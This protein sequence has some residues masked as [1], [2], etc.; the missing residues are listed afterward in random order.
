MKIKKEP[1]TRETEKIE[2]TIETEKIKETKEIEE[3]E[4]INETESIE[5]AESIKEAENTKASKPG[6][7]KLLG[8]GFILA[9]VVLLLMSCLPEDP[10]DHDDRSVYA[11]REDKDLTK[12][13]EDTDGQEPGAEQETESEQESDSG[14]RSESGQGTDSERKSKSEK[15]AGAEQKSKSGKDIGAE[16]K[17][18][19]GQEAE[20]EQKL[21]S[22][23]EAE[24]VSGQ[25]TGPGQ[26]AE[27]EPETASGPK[28]RSGEE[29]LTA[30]SKKALILKNKDQ[31]PEDILKLLEI[32]SMEAI[33]FVLDYPEKKGQVYADDIEDDYEEGKIPLLIQWDERW[34]YGSYGNNVVAVSGCGPTCM[35]MVIAGLTG[36]TDVTPYTMAKYSDE[37]GY[38]TQEGNTMWTFIR[39]GGLDY[40][41]AG[42]D[43]ALDEEIVKEALQAG[44]PVI[45]SM[46]PGD[47]TTSGHFIVLTGYEDGMISVNDPASR[48]RSSQLWTFE[49]L[50]PQ[51]KNLWMCEYIGGE[52]TDDVTYED[53][54]EY[55]EYEEYNEYEEYAGDEE[56]YDY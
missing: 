8:K 47:F 16:Q 43:I 1:E 4:N 11:A 50:A 2:N 3:T 48:I 17:S 36:N 28:K 31:Y 46:R 20:P 38:V 45:C 42:T 5:E 37:N 15:E 55:S 39:E 52:N 27:S 40:G 21:K 12:K 51:I 6:I 34:G 13:A 9:A 35:A 24:P 7:W 18:E 53:D 33:D 26:G 32:N 23:R 19:S 41:V 25:E 29:T 14:Q 56:Y 10:D 30:A 44:K 49:R 54:Y 22:E